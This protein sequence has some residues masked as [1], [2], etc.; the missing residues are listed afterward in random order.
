LTYGDGVASAFVNGMLS[1]QF[2]NLTGTLRTTTGPLKIG[3]RSDSVTAAFPSS[4]FN[5][6]IDEASLYSRALT[7]GEVGALFN[8][9][10]AGKCVGLTCSTPPANLASWLRGEGDASDWTAGHP[11]S[12][13]TPKFAPGKVGQAFDFDGS[14]EVVIGD[15]ANFNLSDFVGR[16]GG[17][18]R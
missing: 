7:T 14:N 6:R 10:N 16:R 2:T 13:A 9:G 17:H 3:S 11:G 8:A 12:F 15:A 4:R 5:G 1:R 18:D